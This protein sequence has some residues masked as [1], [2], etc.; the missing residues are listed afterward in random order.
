MNC[1]C[2]DSGKDGTDNHS[3]NYHILEWIKNPVDIFD[4]IGRR[5]KSCDNHLLCY[6]STGYFKEVS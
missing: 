4:W 3:G 2:N 6:M 5:I 1:V